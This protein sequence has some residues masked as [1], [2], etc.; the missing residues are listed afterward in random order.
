MRTRQVIGAIVAACVAMSLL[1]LAFLIMAYGVVLGVALGIGIAAVVITV[2]A[3]FVGPWQRRWGATDAEVLREM[4]GDDL[5]PASAATTTRA[6]T[7][8]RPP[9]DVFPWLRQIG[10]GRGGWYS[11]DWID[12]D[13]GPSVHHI[14]PAIRLEVGDRIEMLPG[15]GPTVLAIE[16]DRYIL[17]GGETDSW[18][19][20]VE[21]TADGCSRL[22]SRWRQNWPRTFGTYAWIAI[23]DPGAFVMEQRML[24]TIRDLVEAQPDGEPAGIEGGWR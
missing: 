13:G 3:A 18:C 17:S 22:I 1:V 4:P 19:L 23:T 6:I 21:A 10:Y 8:R 16:P 20:Q 14:N 11:Y 5:L 2:Y 24:R 15:L 7:I 12:N 9:C